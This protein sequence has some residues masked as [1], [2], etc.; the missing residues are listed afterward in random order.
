[1][2][3]PGTGRTFSERSL[4]AGVGGF[5]LLSLAALSGCDLKAQD[6]RI[7]ADQ[8]QKENADLRERVRDLTRRVE[9]QDKEIQDLKIENALLEKENETLKAG[10]APPRKKPPEKAG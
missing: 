2:H 8:L 5:P 3:Q 1:M 6:C 4:Y 9:N 10:S 7:K